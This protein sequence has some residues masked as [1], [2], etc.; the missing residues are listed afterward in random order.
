MAASCHR[1]N[2]DSAAPAAVAAAV[3]VAAAVRDDCEHLRP[4]PRSS[5]T[6]DRFDLVTDADASDMNYSTL[7]HRQ[8]WS[9]R[10]NLYW[11]GRRSS[12]SV[13]ESIHFSTIADCTDCAIEDVPAV[14][15][16]VVVVDLA[17]RPMLLSL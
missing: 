6:D 12:L 3:V 7:C 14:D 4:P 1:K 13:A 16:Q 5:T 2:I 11:T 9:G 10:W 17:R 8:C 15:S